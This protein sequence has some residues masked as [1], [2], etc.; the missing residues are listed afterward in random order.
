MNN[1]T[2]TNTKTNTKTSTN[3]NT[4][5]STKTNTKQHPKASEKWLEISTNEVMTVI[6]IHKVG[7][8]GVKQQRV[9]FTQDKTGLK[10]ELFMSVFMTFYKKN[11]E[12]IK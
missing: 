3:T 6:G 4:K 11:K 5:T 9:E 2:K 8:K 7:K 10:E 1:H 12:D